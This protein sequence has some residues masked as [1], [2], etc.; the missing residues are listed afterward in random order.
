MLVAIGHPLEDSDIVSYI[1]NGLADYDCLVTSITTR[2]GPVSLND[3]KGFLLSHELCLE[4]H[5]IAIDLSISIANTA[6]RYSSPNYHPPCGSF[7]NNGLCN[8][9]TNRGHGRDRGWGASYQSSGYN[10]SSPTCQLV[11]RLG[12]LHQ[13]AGSVLIIS[14]CCFHGNH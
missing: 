10:Y 7:H 14:S 8:N 5:I 11:K 2:S 3:L 4:Q 1:L 9:Y 6:Q 12:T 13:T